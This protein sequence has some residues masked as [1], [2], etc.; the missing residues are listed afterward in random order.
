MF[1]RLFILLP[2]LLILAMLLAVAAVPSSAQTSASAE[3]QFPTNT[4]HAMPPVITTPAAPFENYA[5]RLWTEQD[6][7]DTLLRQVQMLSAGDENA[8]LSIRLTQYEIQQRF[9]GA[10]HEPSM[11]GRLLQAILAAPRGS[12]DMRDLVHSYLRDALAEQ[13]ISLPSSASFE[14]AGFHFELTPA[15]MDGVSP[16]DAIIHTIYPAHPADSSQVIYEDYVYATTNAQGRA[17]VLPAA[18]PGY[19]AAPLG[20]VKSLTAERI[21]TFNTDG[22][23]E[24][25]ISLDTGGLNRQ[26]MIMGWRADHVLDLVEPGPGI[27]FGVIKDWPLNVGSPN[28]G[29]LTASVYQVESERWSCIAEQQVVWSW[30]F[31]YYR[32]TPDPRGFLDRHDVGC[33]LYEAEPLFEKPTPQAINAIQTLL[34]SANSGDPNLSR[35]RMALAMVFYLSGQADLASQQVQL[36]ET[37][38]ESDPW[39]AN[40]TAAFDSATHQPDAKPLLV[41]AAVAA[42]DPNGACD[43]DAV[44]TRM[45]T[46]HP[47]QRSQPIESQLAQLGINVLETATVTEVGRLP[48]Q[49][50]HFDL[51]GDRW[52][53]FAPVQRDTYTAERIDSPVGF[54][55]AAVP[56]P[57]SLEA[58]QIAYDALLLND[59]TAGTLNILGNAVR[60]QANVPPSAGF[61]YLQALVYDL[62]GDRTNARQTYYNL[63]RDESG[64]TWGQLA[65]AH[66]ERR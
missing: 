27:L 6:M 7:L 52:W 24:I 12:V 26:L 34:A 23:D 64:S 35:A 39:L 19:P 2:F 30:R 41:C 4:P 62:S 15:N 33:G 40:Q 36:L 59:D 58:P 61:R 20:A 22:L 8:A 1:R 42:A 47:L 48:R 31:N 3:R 16:V 5:L 55:I 32:A 10:P 53:A 45:F 49:A 13:G 43:V 54:Q 9:P 29:S 25:A 38:T 37:L 21:G 66:L 65:A 63:W 17:I 51:A 46:E 11:R 14:Q 57:T 44:L 18:S 56:P 28:S 60:D 50:F